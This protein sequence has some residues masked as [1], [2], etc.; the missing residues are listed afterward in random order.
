[1]FKSAVALVQNTIDAKRATMKKDQENNALKKDPK[2]N[3]LKKD[4]KKMR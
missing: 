2:N 4:L 1:M 3:V